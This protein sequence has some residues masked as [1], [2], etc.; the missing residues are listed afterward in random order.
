MNE[1]KLQPLYYLPIHYPSAAP[2][3]AR[4]KTQLPRPSFPEVSSHPVGLKEKQICVISSHLKKFLE[5][6]SF[7]TL[8]SPPDRAHLLHI[9][10]SFQGHC[11][12]GSEKAF[13]EWLKVIKEEMGEAT[14]LFV[15]NPASYKGNRIQE[16]IRLYQKIIEMAEE[17]AAIQPLLI[18]FFEQKKG[19]SS[20]LDELDALKNAI[21]E[22][23]Y[24][25]KKIDDVIKAFASTDEMSLVSFPLSKE[26]LQQIASEYQQILALRSDIKK[27][28]SYE[29]L[30]VVKEIRQR[31]NTQPLLQKDKL[32][33]ICIGR[34]A[35]RSTFGIFPYNTQIFIL[36]GLLNYPKNLKGRLA[37]VR[38]GEG[39]SVIITLLAFIL[40]CQGLTVDI[41]SSSQPLSVRDQQKYADFFA[42]FEIPTSHLCTIFP[43]KE[44][45]LGQILYGTNTDFEFAHMRMCL[46]LNSLR[47]YPRDGKVIER[48]FDAIIV[49]EADNYFIDTV[50]NS[51]R[52]AIPGRKEHNWVYKPLLS[53]VQTNKE[54]VL[55]MLHTQQNSRKKQIIDQLRKN[56]SQFQNGKFK[57]IVQ[58]F[59]FEELDNWLE[60]AVRALYQ[61]K[62]KV[63]YVIKPRESTTLGRFKKQVVV[64]DQKITGQ[65]L[66]GCRWQ[67]GLHEM[68]EALHEKDGVEIEKENLMPAS[69]CHPIYF[70]HYRRIYGL[71][72]TLGTKIER[73]ELQEINNIDTFDAPPHKPNQRKLLEAKA[74]FSKKEYQFALLQEIQEMQKQGRPILVLL[75]TIENTEEYASFLQERKIHFQL[76]NGCQPAEE[77][78]IIAK[79]GAPGMV[80]IATNKAGRGT[81]IILYPSS[82]AHGG[83]HLI[84]GF[85]PASDRVFDQGIGRAARQGQPGSARWIV[86]VSKNGYTSSSEALAALNKTRA[87]NITRES[88]ERRERFLIEKINHRYLQ[89]F[90]S[91]SQNWQKTIDDALLKSLDPTLQKKAASYTC[92]DLHTENLDDATAKLRKTFHDQA[93]STKPA[94]FSWLPFL[95]SVRHSL[96]TRIHQDWSEFFYEKLDDLYSSLKKESS[97]LEGKA[98]AKAYKGQ[99]EKLHQSVE[100]HWLSDLTSPSF[101]F[102]S[103]LK[104]VTGE[105]YHCF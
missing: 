70:N 85:P 53:F 33:L 20:L 61:T 67:N 6:P 5:K 8:F 48:P 99:V 29:W 87:E 16:A 62:E 98:L 13:V 96:S 104:C 3:A 90:F 12:D 15:S 49:D 32:T 40:A 91:L 71:T 34:E 93:L 77:E 84:F 63:D 26:Q 72:G 76:L 59:S 100:H 31:C 10:S 69:I 23:R 86:D 81:D 82:L 75:E 21:E 1:I 9:L 60:S 38:T 45:F 55:L 51:A 105:L 22:K 2:S 103:Y 68:V 7:Q 47:T 79:A 92:Q 66:E 18:P 46:G 73:D 56:L 30:K 19:L 36:L 88:K 42:F 89:A 35:I 58:E 28:S 27:M 17:I 102:A 101:C 54:S 25:E 50:R 24:A 4:D 65:F 80:T 43:Q 11:L 14:F 78:Y 37:Q 95:K 94:D 52:I 57:T 97:L 64:I 41:V 83:L 44:N 39:K 74:F